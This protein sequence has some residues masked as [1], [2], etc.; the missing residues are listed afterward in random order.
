MKTRTPLLWPALA[1][2]LA[3]CGAAAHAELPTAVAFGGAQAGPRNDYAYLGM[4][5]PLPGAELG[6]GL[7]A[8]AVLSRLG[9]RYDSADNGPVT[10]VNARGPGIEIGAGYTWKHE[11]SNIDLSATVGYRNLDVTPFVPSR[12][13]SGSVLT[14]NPQLSALT[15]LTD[16]V[17][18]DLIANYAIGLGSS[19]ARARVGT[20]PSGNWRAGVEAI[21]LDGRTYQTR[22][23]GIFLSLP[24]DAS[25]ALE[26]SVGRS[27]PGD[28]AAGTYVAVG[29]SF[30]F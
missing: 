16:N 30:T 13:E 23:Q 7:Y 18:A 6:R 19:W 22:Q 8:K 17:S 1:L 10:E 3:T 28:D 29:F 9:Y 27:K 26:I 5:Q 4:I 21:F 24:L 25:S 11:H 12:Q 20:Q 15:Q 14:L 2:G